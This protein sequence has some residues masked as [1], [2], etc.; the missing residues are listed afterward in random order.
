M[1]FLPRTSALVTFLLAVYGA[2]AGEVQPFPTHAPGCI[3]LHDQYDA[4]QKLSFP[5]T[6]VTVLAIADRKGSGQ[7][8][9][10]MAA[11]KPRYAKRIDIRGIAHAGGAPGFLRGKIRKKFQETRTYSVM[12]DWSGSTCEQL[13][14]RK[15]MANI[16]VL[17]RDGAILGRFSGLAN[18]PNVT[19]ACALLDKALSLPA[20]IKPTP[21][22]KNP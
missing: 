4:P 16:L 13:S 6:N 9:G 19:E 7:V 18:G 14:Y 15:E 20:R 17:D 22:A 5:S 21:S 11:L 3:E 8:D 2:V 1:R 12:I 10:W